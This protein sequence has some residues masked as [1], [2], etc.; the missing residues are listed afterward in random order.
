MR[1]DYLRPL[2]AICTTNCLF[3]YP[4]IPRT[5]KRRDSLQ[6]RFANMPKSQKKG[7]SQ[8]LRKEEVM[9]SWPI[10]NQT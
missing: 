1:E 7:L 10:S 4:N 8:V 5:G 2:Q 9:K 3:L 6:D